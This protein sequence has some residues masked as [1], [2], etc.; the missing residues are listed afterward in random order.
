MDTS[1]DIISID[2]NNNEPNEVASSSREK[3]TKNT[4]LFEIF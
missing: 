2:D 4:I 1:E 3:P